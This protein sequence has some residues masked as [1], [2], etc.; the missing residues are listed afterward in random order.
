MR[1]RISELV[2]G[3]APIDSFGVGTELITVRDAPAIS[4]VYKLVELD[5]V[6]RIKK[7]AGKRTY[8]CAKQVVRHR[9]SRGRLAFD[10]IV[11]AGEPIEGEALLVPIVHEGRLVA[12]LPRLDAIRDHC[13]SQLAALPDDLRGLDPAGT[14]RLEYGESL[15]EEARRAGLA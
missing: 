15:E 8:P 12:Q 2:R 7:S 3:G 14:Y 4:M 9:D 11:K 1:S 10:R 13:R 6:G 5:G